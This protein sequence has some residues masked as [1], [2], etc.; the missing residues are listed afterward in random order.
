MCDGLSTQ[1]HKGLSNLVSASKYKQLIRMKVYRRPQIQE[2]TSN[3]VPTSR[4][5]IN[6]LEMCESTSIIVLKALVMIVK[7]M[8]LMVIT[9]AM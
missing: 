6:V 2:G 9:W 1:I 5:I 8:D 3:V 4:V 7:L